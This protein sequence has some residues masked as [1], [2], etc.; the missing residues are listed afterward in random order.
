MVLNQIYNTVIPYTC[1]NQYTFSKLDLSCIAEI[2]LRCDI[3][4]FTSCR[5]KGGDGEKKTDFQT[6]KHIVERSPTNV[7][8]TARDVGTL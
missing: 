6:G 7:R 1:E 4:S 3:V 5:R 8:R 2:F